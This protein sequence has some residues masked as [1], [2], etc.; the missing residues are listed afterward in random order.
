[1]A[2]MINTTPTMLKT[3]FPV[4]VVL[5]I[6]LLA[7]VDIPEVGMLL[8]VTKKANTPTASMISDT[9]MVIIISG[10]MYLNF[11]FS[12]HMF[13][14]ASIYPKPFGTNLIILNGF[15]LNKGYYGIG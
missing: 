15:K 10:F 7:A 1:M 13:S 5:L 4:V 3:W 6:A 8:T 2:P 11:I 9:T 14:T 12:L